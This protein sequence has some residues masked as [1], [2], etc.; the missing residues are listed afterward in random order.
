MNIEIPEG[1]MVP[2]LQSEGTCI[3]LDTWNPYH[4]DLK[5][6][7]HAVLMSPYYWVPQNVK[8][9]EFDDFVYEEVEIRSVAS[10]ASL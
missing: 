2:F 6:L 10:V 7:N 1:D 4:H 9:P 3:F 5:T 8:S